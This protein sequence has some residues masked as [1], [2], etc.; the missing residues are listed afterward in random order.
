MSGWL[1]ITTRNRVALGFAFLGLLCAVTWNFLPWYIWSYS[2]AGLEWIPNGRAGA[3]VWPYVFSPDTYR[4]SGSTGFN[5]NASLAVVASVSLVMHTMSAL[6]ACFLWEVI[7]QT[8]PLKGWLGIANGV[9]GSALILF[10]FNGFFG[11]TS[12]TL[13]MVVITLGM[14]STAAA[15]FIFENEMIMRRQRALP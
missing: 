11:H 7:H 13:T 1:P 10:R 8:G 12:H 9:G 3:M 15:F 2:S 5:L 4:L 6:L 14:F